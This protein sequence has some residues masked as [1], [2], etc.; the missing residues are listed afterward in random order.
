MK[1]EILA[2]T[3]LGLA[4]LVGAAVATVV[5]KRDVKKAEDKRLWIS[6]KLRDAILFVKEY[7][8][9]KRNDMNELEDELNKISKILEENKKINKEEIE[10]IVFKLKYWFENYIKQEGEIEVAGHYI[11]GEK[12]IK[13]AKKGFYIAIEFELRKAL[14]VIRKEIDAGFGY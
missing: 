10:S 7:Q 2:G 3:G 12:E 9:G 13:D 1:K 4:G 11:T 5:L 14:N 6:R 8:A